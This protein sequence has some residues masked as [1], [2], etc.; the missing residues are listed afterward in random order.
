[1]IQSLHKIHMK[2]PVC[3]AGGVSANI[4]IGVHVLPQDPAGF[5]CSRAL[6]DDS[7]QT[8]INT[9]CENHLLS[10]NMNNQNKVM[11]SY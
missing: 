3:S 5:N 8:G 7:F 9:I 2:K 10:Q 1:M 11:H 4:W 6:Q